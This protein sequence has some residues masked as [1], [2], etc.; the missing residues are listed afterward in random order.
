MSEELKV[1]KQKLEED[2]KRDKEKAEKNI[3]ALQKR[4][5]DFIQER[6]Q[7]MKA[8]ASHK[9]IKVFTLKC[10]FRSK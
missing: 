2:T 10:S 8:S 9:S 1:Y 3:A 4:K 6:K 5:E 7:K